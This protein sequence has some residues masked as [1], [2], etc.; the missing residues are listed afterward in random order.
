MKK[1]WS[2]I[3]LDNMLAGMNIDYGLETNSKEASVLKEALGKI[4]GAIVRE[5]YISTN[6]VGKDNVSDMSI[7]LQRDNRVTAKEKWYFN[8]HGNP[9]NHR[10]GTNILGFAEADWQITQIMR[11][12]LDW[13]AQE[14]GIELPKSLYEK[15][16]IGEVFIHSLE[17]AAYSK[18][19]EGDLGAFIGGWWTMYG[20]SRVTDPTCLYRSIPLDELLGVNTR[21][22]EVEYKSTFTVAMNESYAADVGSIGPNMARYRKSSTASLRFYDKEYEIEQKELVVGERELSIISDRLRVDLQLYNKWFAARRIKTV[23]QLTLYVKK[24]YAGD[25]KQ[26]IISEI[27]KVVDKACLLY[28]FSFPLDLFSKER[29]KEIPAAWIKGELLDDDVHA[30]ANRNGIRLDVSYAAHKAMVK[31][32]KT[33]KELLDDYCEENGIELPDSW[34]SVQLGISRLALTSGLA[35]DVVE[36]AR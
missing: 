12:C 33:K 5:G 4:E 23:A 16:S 35:F 13:V 30:W 7:D 6:K 3:M 29:R 36:V 1:P 2:L 31:G 34:K 24:R 15:V 22:D 11:R 8:V 9:V 10:Y 32:R 27:G 25:W 18:K 19:L 28:M 26:F 21:I 14:S 20:M 17:F